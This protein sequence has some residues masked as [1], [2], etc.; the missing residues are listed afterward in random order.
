ML[1]VEMLKEDQLKA[2]KAKLP[3]ATLYTTLLG[4]VERVGKDDGNRLTTDEEL[5]KIV[6]KFINNNNISINLM[7]EGNPAIELI[8]AENFILQEYIPKQLDESQLRER[9][10]SFMET[11]E[12]YNMGSIM[13]Y[14]KEKIPGQYDGKVL[15]KVVREAL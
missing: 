6:K 12:H 8:L 5:I 11:N 10:K 4:E 7:T 2:R 13:T 15:S 3:S 1:L 9:V 14:F